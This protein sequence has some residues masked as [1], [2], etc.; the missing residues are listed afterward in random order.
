MG[1]DRLVKIYF[2]KKM[3]E[4]D[5]GGFMLIS[6]YKLDLSFYKIWHRMERRLQDCGGILREMWKN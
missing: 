1:I 5:D 4:E 2:L 3:T 6:L